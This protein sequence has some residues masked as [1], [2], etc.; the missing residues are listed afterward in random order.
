MIPEV[1][2][3]L[4]RNVGQA[5]ETISNQRLNEFLIELAQLAGFD[6]EVEVMNPWRETPQVDLS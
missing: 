3:F 6:Q 4:N 2:G 1:G 5:P